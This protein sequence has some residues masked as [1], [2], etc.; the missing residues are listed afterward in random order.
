[1]CLTSLGYHFVILL[2]SLYSRC[3][4]FFYVSTS[5]TVNITVYLFPASNCQWSA[6][7]F[8]FFSLQ[9]IANQNFQFKLLF[10]SLLYPLRIPDINVLITVWD[11]PQDRCSFQIV[12]DL[13]WNFKSP[14]ISLKNKFCYLMP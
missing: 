12:L 3:S 8:A 6:A 7:L 14:N 10:S 11:F 2:F 1:M 4:Q 9:I 13:F 5:V